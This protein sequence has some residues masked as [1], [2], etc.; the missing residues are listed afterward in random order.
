MM[1]DSLLTVIHR[2][3]IKFYFDTYTVG[4]IALFDPEGTGVPHVQQCRRF[5]LQEF[6]L[7]A[8]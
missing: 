6:G 5:Q 4:S 7:P 2:C 1:N 3:I 8:E